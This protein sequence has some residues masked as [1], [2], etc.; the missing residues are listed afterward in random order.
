MWPQ[1]VAGAEEDGNEDRADHAARGQRGGWDELRA[2]PARGGAD[3]LQG[4]L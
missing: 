3:G 4:Q 2:A 1:W